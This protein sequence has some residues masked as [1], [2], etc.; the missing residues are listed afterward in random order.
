MNSNVAMNHSNQSIN[1]T[2]N[3]VKANSPKAYTNNIIAMSDV[4][5][6]VAL[7]NHVTPNQRLLNIQNERMHIVASL[8][9]RQAPFGAAGNSG[10]VPQCNETSP[11]LGNPN[12][13]R[14]VV[15][16]VDTEQVWLK[17]GKMMHLSTAHLQGFTCIAV[18]VGKI[19]VSVSTIFLLAMK[20][21]T[22]LLMPS[23]IPIHQELAP[24]HDWCCL[25]LLWSLKYDA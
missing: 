8:T 24:L 20:A 16:T 14:Q 1:S 13:R 19:R 3:K 7:V 4:N 9:G 25:W 18:P 21:S 22:D 23:Q 10:P 15:G 12:I 17:K 11:N 6:A 5:E 2:K